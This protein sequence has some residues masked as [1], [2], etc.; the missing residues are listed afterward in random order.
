MWRTLKSTTSQAVLNAIES[1]TNVSTQNLT[2]KRKFK[3]KRE[4]QMTKWWFVINA[5]EAILLEL[6]TA[7]SVI[8]QQTE[9]TLGPVLRYPESE[10]DPVPTQPTKKVW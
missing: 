7:W 5:D 6:E 4:G 2:I 1:L 3:E 9:W 10:S 8:E